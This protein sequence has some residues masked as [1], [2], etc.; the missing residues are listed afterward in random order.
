MEPIDYRSVQRL[1]SSWLLFGQISTK[2]P[3]ISDFSLR[4]LTKSIGAMYIEHPDR[5]LHD[6]ILDALSL[7]LFEESEELVIEA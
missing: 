5:F 2:V 4:K 6:S 3:L 1:F 7:M